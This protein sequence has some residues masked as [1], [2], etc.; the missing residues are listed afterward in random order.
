MAT[1]L[2]QGQLFNAVIKGLVTPNASWYDKDETIE[3]INCNFEPS[4]AVGWAI[5]STRDSDY[6]VYASYDANTKTVNISI[7]ADIN[8]FSPSNPLKLYLDADSSGMFYYFRA[9]EDIIFFASTPGTYY[10]P[11]YVPVVLLWDKVTN[12]VA[13]NPDDDMLVGMFEKCS[14]L[15]NFGM[16][17]TEYWDSDT[18]VLGISSLAKMFFDCQSLKSCSICLNKEQDNTALVKNVM[19][20][21]YNCE[22]LEYV[23]LDGNFSEAYAGA[24][25]MFYGCENLVIFTV[26]N[27]MTNIRL[28]L[29]YY[30]D[31]ST[32]EGTDVVY[33]RF[34]FLKDSDSD[35]SNVYSDLASETVPHD[36]PNDYKWARKATLLDIYLDFEA[37][38]P[39]DTDIIFE[40]QHGISEPAEPTKKGYTFKGWYASDKV[41]PFDFTQIFDRLTLKDI[42]VYANWTADALTVTF[43][44]QG[45]SPVAPYTD[46]A[47]GSTISR[48]TNPT[49]TGY[50]FSNWYTDTTFETMW[51]FTTDV[52]TEDMTLYALWKTHT[53]TVFFNSKG[54]SSVEPI[55]EVAYGETITAP[56]APT[57][58][59]YAFGGWYKEEECIT[60]WDFDN[61]VVYVNTTLYAKWTI[62][63]FSVTFD[64]NGGS[65]ISPYTDVEYGS[66]ITEPSTPEKLENTFDGWYKDAEFENAWDFENDTVTENITLYAK[67]VEWSK[68]R[69]F[70]PNAYRGESLRLTRGNKVRK[71]FKPFR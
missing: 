51:D 57:R 52:V 44:S 59:G 7:I 47:S 19:N 32:K 13:T 14:S 60:P 58:T 39:Y 43:D 55:Y 68:S 71:E 49:K 8:N 5:V 24:K 1:K 45:G 26:P 30:T 42:E 9:L 40:K 31:W 66:K 16:V 53:S 27:G 63:T 4:A 17:S 48:P 67:W 23:V 12:I 54:G 15:K 6:E 46:V 3:H 34:G 61:D 28:N 22:D 56:T 37:S 10:V 62:Q 25:N 2:I 36:L 21:F 18:T 11:Y 38:T 64:S 35:F 50:D 20:M 29:P 70:N 41:T 65:L 69:I 33:A